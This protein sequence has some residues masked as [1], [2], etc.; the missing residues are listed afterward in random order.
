[1][2]S[3][4]TDKPMKLVLREKKAVFRKEEF[5][6]VQHIYLCEDTKE[7]MMTPEQVHINIEQLHNAYCAKHNIPNANTIRRIR[8]QYGIAAAKMSEIMEFGINT[9]KQYEDGDIPSLPNARLIRKIAAQPSEFKKQVEECQTIKEKEKQAILQRIEVLIKENEVNFEEDLLL[10]LTNTKPNITTGYAVFNAA[11]FMNMITYFASEMK[12]FKTKLNKLLFYADFLH[13]KKNGISISGAQYRAIQYGPV[14]AD[15]QFLYGFAS[16]KKYV[17]IEEYILK[18]KSNVSEKF[19]K[20]K[21]DFDNSL[22]EPEELET[23]AVVS[24]FFEKL[25]TQKTIQFS[26]EEKAWKENEE[27][28]NLI[29]YNY[30]FEVMI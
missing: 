15:Y 25:D 26:H 1:M 30:A 14:P 27:L 24:H 11:K 8:E 10:S 7:E 13:F 16:R 23:L 18:D 6:I 17:E 22:F 20:S 4:F 3:P 9:Y 28:H 12:P 5:L 19:I 2:N 29:S 21:H